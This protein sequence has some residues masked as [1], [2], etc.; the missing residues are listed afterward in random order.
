MLNSHYKE[1]LLAAQTQSRTNNDI[2][3][4]SQIQHIYKIVMTENIPVNELTEEMLSSF[5]EKEQLG[6]T[7]Y[8]KYQD[9]EGLKHCDL[10]KP[11][12]VYP[13]NNNASYPIPNEQHVLSPEQIESI[14]YQ[15]MR[16][17]KL[18]LFNKTMQSLAQR[19]D[20]TKLQTAF[21][22]LEE[23]KECVKQGL[24]LP[25]DFLSKL[26]KWEA[27]GCTEVNFDFEEK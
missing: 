3:C 12:E 21:P 7:D 22:Y 26:D 13:L 4:E 6:Q 16:M 24:V 11:V 10:S 20:G 19:D 1:A 17:G 9:K 14:F 15:L 5:L 23:I 18:S 8:S 2:E 27:L 25:S